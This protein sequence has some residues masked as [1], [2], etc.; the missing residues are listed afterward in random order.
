MKKVIEFITDMVDGGAETLVKDYALLL[1]RNKFE[2]IILTRYPAHNTANMK[3]LENSGIRVISINSSNSFLAKVWNKLTFRFRIPSVM[4]KI[5][6]EEKPDVIHAHLNQLE[7]LK[8]ISKD[9]KG[10]KL[11]YTCHNVVEHY[12]GEK[13]VKEREA[14]EYLIKNNNLRMI[15]LH[16][17]MK[18]ELNELFKVDNTVV[19]RNGINFER[20]R[21]VSKTK[22][23]K[24]EEINIPKD[25][26]VIG[27]IG[28]FAEQKNHPFLVEIFREVCK[29]N[30]KAFLLMIGAGDKSYVINKLAE[31]GLENKYMIL[32]GR[33]DVPELM[34]AM[35]VF[36]F[37]SK[38]EGLGIVLV[39]AQTC[40]LKCICSSVVPQEAFLSDHIISLGLDQP[41]KIWADT[42][43]NPEIK[44][45]YPD[46]LES[47][48]MK[49]TIEQLEDL[50]LN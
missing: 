19:I 31:Y 33:S 37:P 26:F 27:H 23:E 4:R 35:D 6:R 48:D 43:L 8:S 39:E 36:V 5:I 44:S 45:D 7:Y 3:Q 46:R 41:L 38:F 29:R 40:G 24:R 34:R 2:T 15:A 14:A 10:I 22:D 50:Y 9:L 17:D 28:R 16:D 18:N 25:A 21:N 30:D 11:I 1:D 13:C 20:F 32:S 47:Y 49:K 12:F 42:I